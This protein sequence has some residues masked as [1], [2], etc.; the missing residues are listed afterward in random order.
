MVL[1]SNGLRELWGYTGFLG[2]HCFPLGALRAGSEAGDAAAA[3]DL[4][5]WRSLA[6]S[7]GWA[8]QGP[9]PALPGTPLSLPPVPYL[10]TGERRR[11]NLESSLFSRP[12][13][14]RSG[15]DPEAA[16]RTVS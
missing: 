2:S 5:P 9:R 10:L 12:G 1:R 16:R 15:Q 3:P 6:Q 13:R 11:L 14:G 7:P 8:Y 4:L